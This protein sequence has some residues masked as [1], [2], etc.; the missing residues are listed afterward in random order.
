M[1]PFRNVSKYFEI[2]SLWDGIRFGKKYGSKWN[3]VRNEIRFKMDFRLQPN[4]PPRHDLCNAYYF[5]FTCVAFMQT[6]RN[7]SHS[8]LLSLYS[9]VPLLLLRHHEFS[10]IVP[11]LLGTPPSN[12]LALLTCHSNVFLFKFSLPKT[13][14]SLPVAP[15]CYNPGSSTWV[16]TVHSLKFQ[17]YSAVE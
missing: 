16:F 3:P 4:A 5:R 12:L 1:H 2:D 15:K 9:A 13:L 11:S 7:T 10:K 17:I 14:V 6:A 8:L